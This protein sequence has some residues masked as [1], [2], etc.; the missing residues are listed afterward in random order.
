MA[1]QETYTKQNSKEARGEYT[2]YFSGENQQN[3]ST[4]TAGVGFVIHNDYSKYIEE[5]IPHTDRIIQ[6]TLKG[7]LN[8]NLINI[9]IGIKMPG[10]V[11]MKKKILILMVK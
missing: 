11:H 6:L 4:W 10:I 9:I 3:D 1:L 8:I 7:S 5:I 2:W